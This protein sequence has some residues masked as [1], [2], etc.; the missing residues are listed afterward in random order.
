MAAPHLKTLIRRLHPDTDVRDLEKR[1]RLPVNTIAYYLKPSVKIHRIPTADVINAIAY[2]LACDP[3]E[4][5]R[6]FAADVNIPMDQPTL[7]DEDRDLLG[8]YRQL[9]PKRR[10]TLRHVA[11]S[12]L[13]ER[14]WNLTRD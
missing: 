11:Q 5:V 1:A 4:V 12:L 13:E 3:V 10:Q 8:L 2:A 9:D 14:R 6:A 7:N